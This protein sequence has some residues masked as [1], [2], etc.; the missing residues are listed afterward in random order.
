MAR[1]LL[2]LR[3]NR[4]CNRSTDPKKILDHANK[5]AGTQEN[6]SE[7]IP[8][9]LVSI[10][11]SKCA[12]TRSW[13]WASSKSKAKYS[14]IVNS[15]N[16]CEEWKNEKQLESANQCKAKQGRRTRPWRT[17]GMKIHGREWTRKKCHRSRIHPERSLNYKALLGRKST[18]PLWRDRTPTKTSRTT[19][20]N[21]LMR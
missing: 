15:K 4:C 16:H 9:A 12:M 6:N 7:A 5:I 8:S 3:W 2:Q 21:K 13:N 1:V 17:A 20:D 11:V 10:C 19:K 18:Q 14:K